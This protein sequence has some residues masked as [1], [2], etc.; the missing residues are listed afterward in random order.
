MSV[1][2]LQN[3]RASI[4]RAMTDDERRVSDAANR[5]MGVESFVEDIIPPIVI[6]ITKKA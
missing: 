2:D 4:G 1:S 5:A 3:Q 6:D